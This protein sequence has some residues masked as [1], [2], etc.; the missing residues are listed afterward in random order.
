MFNRLK[1][2]FEKPGGKSSGQEDLDK[3]DTVSNE[4]VNTIIRRLTDHQ[5]VHA[6]TAI[7]GAGSIAGN[8]LLRATGYDF[9]KLSPGSAVF[10]DQVNEA[11]PTILGVMSAVC[12]KLDINPQTGW[13]TPPPAENASQ[14]S[15]ID[16][17]KLL[18]PDFDALISTH[19][20]SKDV[21]PLV[22]AAAAI[23]LVKLA[24]ATLNPEIGKAIAINSV[25]A[26]SKTVPYPN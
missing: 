25:V 24:S 2:L 23:K 20:V 14:R 18:R 1:K 9:S 22:A 4:F 17:V 12:A 5:G 26:G 11:G 8:S 3:L 6:E 15:I 21:E 16:L 10:T 7:T 13:N 19:K